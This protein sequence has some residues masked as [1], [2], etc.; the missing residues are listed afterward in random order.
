MPEIQECYCSGLQL[1]S[2][3]TANKTTDWHLI[4]LYCDATKDEPKDPSSP[5]ARGLV[6]KLNATSKAKR[7]NTS[8]QTPLWPPFL[9]AN[10]PPAGFKLEDLVL[11]EVHYTSR[12]IVLNFGHCWFQL[13]Y[14]T[15]TSIQTYHRQHWEVLK[16]TSYIGKGET[17]MRSF[18]IGLAMEFEDFVIAFVSHDQ[19]F[20]V[21]SSGKNPLVNAP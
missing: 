11:A 2:F 12:S 21:T 18:R 13:Q 19:V 3:H 16:E 14:L 10:A 20:Q 4:A 1:Q 7:G 15:H 9:A 6:G 5:W 8:H 17:A